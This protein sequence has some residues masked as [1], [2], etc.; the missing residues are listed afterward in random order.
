MNPLVLS[1]FDSGLSTVSLGG[2]WRTRA[3]K[4]VRC[5]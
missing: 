3:G 1:P 2:N 4:L 5:A